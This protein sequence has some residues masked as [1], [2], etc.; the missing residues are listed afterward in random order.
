MQANLA[1]AMEPLMGDL[2]AL[3]SYTSME[4]ALEEALKSIGYGICRQT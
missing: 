4:I 2:G 3:K 1:R